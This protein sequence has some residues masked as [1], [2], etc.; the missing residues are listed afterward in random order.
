[1]NREGEKRRHQDHWCTF[2]LV[3]I[4]ASVCEGC[5]CV[6]TVMLLVFLGFTGS[7]RVYHIL[8]Y[9][10]GILKTDQITIIQ[11]LAVCVCEYGC[12]V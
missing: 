9:I 3:F 6:V 7:L 1:M 5:Y 2:M 10:S 11:V 8:K 12:A 4:C